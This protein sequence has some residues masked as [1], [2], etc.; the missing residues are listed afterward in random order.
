MA[1]QYPDLKDRP[2][3]ETICL[4]DVDGTLSPARQ[5]ATPEMLEI[6]AKLRQKIA[7][8]YVCLTWPNDLGF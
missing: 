3:K 4:F 5:H 2:I 7:I 1:H 8:G 6:L